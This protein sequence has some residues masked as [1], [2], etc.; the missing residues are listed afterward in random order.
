MALWRDDKYLRLV[1]SQLE[2]FRQKSAHTYNF[3][4]PLC[5]DSEKNLTKTRGYIFPKLDI[6]MFKCHNCA[7]ALPFS[8]LLKRLSRRLYAE[9]TME[10]LKDEQPVTQSIITAPAAPPQTPEPRPP[11]SLLTPTLAFC[12]LPEHP[13]HQVYRFAKDIRQ[14]PDTAM[15]R[16]NATDRAREWLCP[17]V[18]TEKA[19]K[20]ADGTPYLVQPL[21]LPN[22]AW[23]GAQLRTLEKKDFLTFRWSHEPLKLFGL[24]HWSSRHLTYI[25]EGPI[26]SLFIPNCLSPCG[27]DLISGMQVLED[28]GMLPVANQRVFIWD[29]EP[30]N[31]EISRHLR[32]AIALH[33]QVVIWSV[34]FKHKDINDAVRAGVDINTL[35]KRRT[36]QGMSAELQFRDWKFG[37]DSTCLK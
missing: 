3:R 19:A 2:Q 10:R 27:S 33:E 28:M 34:A 18:G 26:D 15:A 4:C 32:A 17:L 20:V 37:K 30:K 7:V 16:L 21:T 29:N 14:L 9:Y 1:S 13:L 12:A 25:V 24:D 5:G 23:Y 11:P 36:F 22:G 6:L 31:S 8:A 35:I